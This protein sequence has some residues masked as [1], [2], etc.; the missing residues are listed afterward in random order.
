[1][2]RDEWTTY[3]NW[4][5]LHFLEH[6][7]VLPCSPPALSP[8]PGTPPARAAPC[9]TRTAGMGRARGRGAT[10]S[11]RQTGMCPTSVCAL[12]RAPSPASTGTSPAPSAA[13][14][15]SSASPPH[16]A[17]AAHPYLPA[18]AADAGTARR[19]GEGESSLCWPGGLG[20]EERRGAASAERKGPAAP[21]LQRRSRAAGSWCHSYAVSHQLFTE[22]ERSHSH[23]IRNSSFPR[24][25]PP[26]RAAPIPTRE[27][28]HWPLAALRT[29]EK[30]RQKGGGGRREPRHTHRAH[31]KPFDPHPARLQS[32]SCAS[33]WKN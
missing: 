31:K 9:L 2:L 22:F 29:P 21:S 19:W 24:R 27:G 7:R 20:A 3:S 23:S 25:H 10:P 17:F 13:L 12:F 5:A 33:R 14:A 1:M 18:G 15:P 28:A 30:E 16:Q 26:S 6:Q 11:P 8:T 32:V 4:C